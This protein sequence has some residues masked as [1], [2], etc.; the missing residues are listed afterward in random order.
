MFWTNFRGG[1][2]RRLANMPTLSFFAMEN[3][4]GFPPEPGVPF[5]FVQAEKLY[6]Y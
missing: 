2:Q 3:P 4:F 1:R 5:R 6:S